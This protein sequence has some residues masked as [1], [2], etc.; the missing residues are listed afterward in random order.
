MSTISSSEELFPLSQGVCLRRHYRE[1]GR[2]SPGR[3]YPYE[4]DK[5]LRVG[6]LPYKIS[7][8]YSTTEIHYTLISGSIEDDLKYSHTSCLSDT[9]NVGWYLNL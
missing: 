2:E 8:F 1:P 6:N 7:V 4:A 5:L 3:F 9:A